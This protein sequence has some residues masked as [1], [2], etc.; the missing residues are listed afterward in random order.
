MPQDR[1]TGFSGEAVLLALLQNNQQGSSKW[2][3]STCDQLRQMGRDVLPSLFEFLHD[4][5]WRIRRAS[6][7]AIGVINDPAAVPDL[8]MALRDR[9]PAVKSAAV[10][11]LRKSGKAAVP[12]LIALLD[13]A[14]DYVRSRSVRLLGSIRDSRAV[15]GLLQAFDKTP[16][17]IDRNEIVDALFSIRDRAGLCDLVRKACAKRGDWWEAVYYK[18]KDTRSWQSVPSLVLLLFDLLKSNDPAIAGCAAA[19]LG[20]ISDR[21]VAPVLA[22]ALQDSTDLVRH[23]ATIALSNIGDRRAVPGLIAM[24]SSKDP[25]TRFGAVIRLKTLGDDRAVPALEKALDDP[26]SP[27]Q[28]HAAAGLWSSGHKRARQIILEYLRHPDPRERSYTL[29]ALAGTKDPDVIPFI[30]A[31]LQDKDTKLNAI[32]DLGEFR[33]S[34]EAC[35]LVEWA[36]KGETSEDVLRAAIDAFAKIGRPEAIPIL[37]PLAHLPRPDSAV[38]WYAGEAIRQ[39]EKAQRTS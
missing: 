22:Q 3:Q 34:K 23:Y 4:K 17:Y 2:D 36:I 12:G 10:E 9:H 38:S 1:K 14:D 8:L 6:V 20:R 18:L 21:R 33:N 35:S 26:D 27:V 11:S 7:I 24:M 37:Q 39:I 5:N 29:S 16:G 15:P 30:E 19:L 32:R 28:Q 31:G 25:M 13:D